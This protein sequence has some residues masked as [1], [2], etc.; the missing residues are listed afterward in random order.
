MSG[1]HRILAPAIC[2]KRPG[3]VSTRSDLLA[4]K[5]WSQL[6]GTSAVPFTLTQGLLWETWLLG[7]RKQARQ[8]AQVDFPLLCLFVIPLLLLC[9]PRLLYN[10]SK[11]K[12]KRPPAPLNSTASCVW[13]VCAVYKGIHLCTHTEVRGHQIPPLA[14]SALL[15]WGRM[16]PRKSASPC[17]PLVSASTGADIRLGP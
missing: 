2:L 9:S 12:A 16:S 14:I 17:N 10:F 7:H 8:R 15:F 4:M 6:Q 13:G 5:L 3:Y 11:S 1:K